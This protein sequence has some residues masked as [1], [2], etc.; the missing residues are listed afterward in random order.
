M[1]YYIELNILFNIEDFVIKIQKF[2][3]KYI[4]KKQ[5]KK[6]KKCYRNF[7][8]RMKKEGSLGLKPN[9]PSIWGFAPYLKL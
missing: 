8:N 3:K 6:I 5:F 7:Q 4:I 1:D 2:Y 9:D